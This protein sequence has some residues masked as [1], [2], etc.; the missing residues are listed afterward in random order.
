MEA[1]VVDDEIEVRTPGFHRSRSAQSD[2]D[3]TD[4]GIEGYADYCMEGR[5]VTD[6]DSWVFSLLGQWLQYK[7]LELEDDL[8]FKS[9]HPSNRFRIYSIVNY[10]GSRRRFINAS[11]NYASRNLYFVCNSVDAPSDYE[12]TSAKSFHPKLSERERFYQYVNN[13]G[14]HLQLNGDITTQEDDTQ[15]EERS[16][17]QGVNDRDVIANLSATQMGIL[18]TFVP[19]ARSYV[20]DQYALAR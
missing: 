11:V 16:Y 12:S 1:F 19:P 6:K 7:E 2:V 5:H 18:L 8:E 17:M 3:E 13:V 10:N 15:Q 20:L 9:K 14:E 4:F